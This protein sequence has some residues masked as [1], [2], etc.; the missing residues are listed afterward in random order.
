[1]NTKSAT[2]NLALF[3]ARFQPGVIGMLPALDAFRKAVPQLS[4]HD[5]A[6]SLSILPT[7]VVNALLWK[8]RNN[9]PSITAQLTVNT[10]PGLT[11][12]TALY[13]VAV[14]FKLASEP[15]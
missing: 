12:V 9:A 10:L 1:M 5:T 3:L 7:T 13:P 2:L 11:G 8:N 14:V 4:K 15:F 6:L